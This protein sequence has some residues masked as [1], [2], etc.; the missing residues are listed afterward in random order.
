MR[1]SQVEKIED[2]FTIEDL[3][4]KLLDELAE[5][6]YDPPE[7]VR[8]Y[9]QNAVDAHR[10][11]KNSTGSLPDR[12]I[13]IE[14]GES[15]RSIIFHDWGVGMDEDE[16]KGVK[17]VG[18]SSKPSS[19]ASL[20]GYKGVGIWAGFNFF[21]RISL[22]STKEGISKGYEL[23]IRFSDIREMV[24]HETNIGEVLNENFDIYVHEEK[25]DVG[26]TRAELIN[27][28]REFFLDP[29]QVKKSV[30]NT[31]PCKIDS[32]FKYSNEVESWY[33]SNGLQFFDISV[34][35]ETVTRSYPDIVH[36]PD[37]GEIKIGDTVVAKYWR[38]ITTYTKAIDR[39]IDIGQKKLGFDIFKKGFVLGN[40]LYTSDRDDRF[41][42]LSTQTY[43]RWQFGEIHIVSNDI[44][45]KVDRKDIDLSDEYS[46]EFVRNLRDKY[47]DFV[48]DARY[49]SPYNK[50]I[51]K[52]KEV[53]QKIS[54][55]GNKDELREDDFDVAKE[56]AE[57]L[58]EHRKT[59]LDHKHESTNKKKVIAT[60]DTKDKRR[61]LFTRIEDITG[62]EISR[63][64]EEEYLEADEDTDDSSPAADSSD[65]DDQV[66]DDG[67]D[68]N[69]SSEGSEDEADS[70]TSE[71][72]T[73]GNKTSREKSHASSSESSAS[74]SSGSSDSSPNEALATETLLIVV[75]DVL[76]EY[77]YDSEK[78]EDMI[79]EIRHRLSNM[80]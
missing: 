51:D 64:D 38:C 41:Q 45:P 37:T 48:S 14:F 1:D 61:R 36:S 54:E 53:D 60:R 17:A 49:I 46:I 19:S 47:S 70:S 69:K 26:F 27:A 59:F 20:T 77:L 66:A 68:E 50:I 56:E 35:G 29:K 30:I 42:K 76:R 8:E 25:G 31:C 15:N 11:V 4:S 57:K 71:D 58:N 21:D 24:S 18:I 40:N 13:L 62:G 6:L 75:E 39:S 74:D 5:G 78:T 63:I 43:L 67:G 34:A 23:E 22:Y 73:V 33:E 16:I 28:R 52:Y 2:K 9:V 3:G 65:D 10:E 72:S 12:P 32:S 55:I 7:V 44:L 80:F 79:E